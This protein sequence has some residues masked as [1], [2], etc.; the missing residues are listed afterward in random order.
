MFCDPEQMKLEISNKEKL[1]KFT[2][3]WKL[4]NVLNKSMGQSRN[5]KGN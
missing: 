3:T 5:H 2:N 1:E 4:N